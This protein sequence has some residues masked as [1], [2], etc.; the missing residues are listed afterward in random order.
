[1]MQ[2]ICY[3]FEKGWVLTRLFDNSE[4]LRYTTT[5]RKAVE[6]LTTEGSM[7]NSKHP[8]ITN[9]LS[10]GIAPSSC[11]HSLISSSRNFRTW[12]LGNEHSCTWRPLKER[13]LSSLSIPSLGSFPNTSMPPSSNLIPDKHILVTVY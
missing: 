12:S 3:F 13:Q 4:L 2:Y 9:F 5:S 10:P 11:F 1:M 8:S 6:L 7:V